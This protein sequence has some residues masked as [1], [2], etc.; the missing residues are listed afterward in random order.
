MAT[1]KMLEARGLIEQGKY[2]EA[3]KLLQT[4]DHPKARE[5]LE[6]INALETN[7]EFPSSVP[8]FNSKAGSDTFQRVISAF[9]KNNWVVLSRTDQSASLEKKA[10]SYLL[11]IILGIP[12]L[13]LLLFDRLLYAIV[14]ISLV[15]ILVVFNNFTK[16]TKS[17][18][19]NLESDG[20]VVV[21]ANVRRV[22][23]K[24]PPGFKGSIHM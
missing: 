10:S 17:A 13:Y 24:Y 14:C 11:A 6:K 16:K 22:S 23:H 18:H 8:T 9:V 4:I 5:W 1:E 12:A 2:V 15:I 19:I 21:T 7:L 3:R 20:T